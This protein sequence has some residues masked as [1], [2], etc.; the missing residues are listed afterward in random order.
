[1]IFGSGVPS[2]ICQLA[3]YRLGIE[4]SVVTAERFF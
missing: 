2:G 4:A 3:L 1:M